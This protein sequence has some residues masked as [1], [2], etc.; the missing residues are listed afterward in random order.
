MPSSRSR[1]PNSKNGAVS[2]PLDKVDTV[3]FP[4]DATSSETLVN[5][6]NLTFIRST[7]NKEMQRAQEA[8]SASV[9]DVCSQVC[10]NI[11][12]Q[13]Y[14][15]FDSRLNQVETGLKEVSEKQTE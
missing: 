3:D 10:T 12:G 7:I 6:S 15:G 5:H 11:N 13:L 4:S 1:S 2:Q 9:A 8:M 14:Q